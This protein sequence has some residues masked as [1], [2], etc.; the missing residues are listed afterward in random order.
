MPALHWLLL[1][2]KSVE[3]HVRFW[4]DKETRGLRSPLFFDSEDSDHNRPWAKKARTHRPDSEQLA[5]IGELMKAPR[6][7]FVIGELRPD[8]T[9]HPERRV[10]SQ[11]STKGGGAL[12]GRFCRGCQRFLCRENFSRNG[13]PAGRAIC[14]ACDVIRATERR[15][16]RKQL[17][18]H[19]PPAEQDK[20]SPLGELSG[21]IDGGGHRSPAFFVSTNAR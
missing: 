3:S 14:K 5:E 8:G 20:I 10:R 21:Q 9:V 12:L 6:P 15:N 16:K 19:R 2:E 13:K 18:I 7:G 11:T 1:T 17:Q 4:R